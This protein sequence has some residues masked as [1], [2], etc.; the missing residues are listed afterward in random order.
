MSY[1]RRVRDLFPL[2]LTEREASAVRRQRIDV[3]YDVAAYN[4]A[5]YKL[6]W[7]PHWRADD[8]PRSLIAHRRNLAR[9]R[10]HRR[11]EAR[12]QGTA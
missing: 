11:R 10:A 4:R 3:P 6:S 12:K 7:Q 1:R 2:L 8:H 5:I 9:H